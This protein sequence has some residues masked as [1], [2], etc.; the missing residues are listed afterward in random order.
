MLNNKQLL[1]G[2]SEANQIELIVNLLGSPNESIWPGFSS[3]PL[4]KELVLKNQ[5]YNNLKQKFHWLSEAGSQLVND[6]LTYDPNKRI[7]ARKA[8]KS[9][10][11]REKPHPIEPEMMPTYP[12]LRNSKPQVHRKMPAE[13]D[14]AEEQKPA[15]KKQKRYRY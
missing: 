12:H 10:Y 9:A 4:V 3:L 6:M 11:F 14:A 5:P 8:R 7:S 13:M 15:S 1:P 2:K